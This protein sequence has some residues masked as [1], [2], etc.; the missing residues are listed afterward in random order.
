[1][2][3]VKTAERNQVVELMEGVEAACANRYAARSSAHS[4][5]FRSMAHRHLLPH[6][7]V[8]RCGVPLCT[9]TL[10]A[11][12]VSQRRR[13]CQWKNSWLHGLQR[14]EA[15]VEVATHRQI[16][17]VGCQRHPNRTVNG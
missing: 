13:P 10:S 2:M 4:A 16:W 5:G 3:Q 1:M 8:A 15:S 9:I 6:L 17:A 14:T 11:V 7:G 12:P